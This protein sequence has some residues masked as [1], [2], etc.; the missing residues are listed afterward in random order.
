MSDKENVKVDHYMRDWGVEMV[1]VNKEEYA[2]KM[3]IIKENAQTPYIYH[4]KRKK[5]LFLLQNAVIL[6]IEGKNRM[7]KEKE[8]FDIAPKMM[9]RLKAIKGEV[10][11]LE[12]STKIED[13]IVVVED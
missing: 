6:D 3:I 10:T 8:S 4:K 5:T 13:D 7:L 11:L 9:H 2:C 1:L 12:I